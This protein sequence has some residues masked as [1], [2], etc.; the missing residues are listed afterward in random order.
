MLIKD[1]P[2]RGVPSKLQ[3]RLRIRAVRSKLTAVAISCVA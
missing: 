1:R 2:S 3:T